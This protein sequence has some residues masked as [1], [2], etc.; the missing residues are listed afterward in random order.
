MGH[1]LCDDIG[2]NTVMSS[3]VTTKKQS[4]VSLTSTENIFHI[5]FAT[6]RS[7]SCFLLTKIL[8]A[9]NNKTVKS[10]EDGGQNRTSFSLSTEYTLKAWAM[11]IIHSD[12]ETECGEMFPRYGFF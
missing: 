4:T 12:G 5:S 7:L 8:L 11:L 2:S 3:S 6:I 10:Q 1:K 9:T